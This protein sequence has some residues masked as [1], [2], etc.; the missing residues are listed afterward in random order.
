M[1]CTLDFESRD[2]LNS[3]LTESLIMKD[4][5][6]PNVLGLLGVCLDAPDGSPHIVLPFMANGSLKTYLKEKRTHVLDVDSFPEVKDCAIL[7]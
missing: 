3:F 6:H 7:S 1:S 5:K 2:Q 4:F